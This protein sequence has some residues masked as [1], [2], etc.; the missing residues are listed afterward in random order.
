MG[1][2]FEVGEEWMCWAGRVLS[3]LWSSGGTL[4][5][6]PRKEAAGFRAGVFVQQFFSM[7]PLLWQKSQ[8][9]DF[10]RAILE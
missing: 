7:C 5:L 6:A 3:P 9:R 10:L 2:W 1:L 4:V 8:I